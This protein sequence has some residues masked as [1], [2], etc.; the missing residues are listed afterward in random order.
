MRI[1]EYKRPT[2]EV[3]VDEP[4]GALRL[5]R[6]ASLSGEVRYYFGLPVVTGS[7]VWRVE[8]EPVYPRWWYWWYGA[9]SAQSEI[10]AAGKTSLDAEGRF[11][12]SLSPAPTSAR[13]ARG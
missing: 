10:V 13:R 11:R 8:R 12:V 6:E 2:F 5:N 3:T 9:P 1:E 7:V 4:E